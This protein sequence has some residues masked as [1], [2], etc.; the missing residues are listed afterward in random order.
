MGVASTKKPRL[1]LV[2]PGQKR[3]GRNKTKAKRKTSSFSAADLLLTL[4]RKI[5][6]SGAC[7]LLL[8]VLGIGC[9]AGYRWMTS[10]PYFALQDIKVS[11]NQRLTYGEVLS[12]AGISLNQNSLSVNIGEVES[13]LSDNLWINSA[14]VKRQLPGEMHIL[15]REKTP[16]FMVRQGDK[17]YYCDSRGGLIAPVNPAKFTSL[18]FLNIDSD[19]MDKA[20]ILPDFMDRLSRRELPFDAGQIAWIDIKGGNRMEIFMDSLNLKL[21]LGLNN[22]Q[23]QLSHLNTVWNDLKNR[24]EFRDV[25]AITTGDG[26]VW[27]EKHTHG[28]GSPK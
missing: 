12:L 2:K 9:L 23:E 16:R 1:T 7:L 21:L 5:C 15:V 28:N 27:V 14:T 3:T 13:R 10:H 19:A 25:A 4:M 6:I 17:L 11:G 26:R 18:P 24:G 22:W 20:A 8:A